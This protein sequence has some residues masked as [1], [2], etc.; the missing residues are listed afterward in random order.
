[1]PPSALVTRTLICS[2]FVA[3]CGSAVLAQGGETPANSDV[4]ARL[5]AL[6]QRVKELEGDVVQPKPNERP[7]IRHEATHST[8]R[9]FW[10]VPGTDIGIKIGGYTKLDVIHDFQD[11]GNR[12][13][14][15][16]NSIP[17]PSADQSRTTMHARESRLFL[18]VRSTMEGLPARVYVEGD[19]FGDGNQ[20]ELR[21]A[22]GQWGGLLAGQTWTT[23]M[24]V[25]SRPHTLDFEGP[26]AE[27]FSRN[28]MVRWHSELDDGW[29][30]AVAIEDATQQFANTGGAALP[31]QSITTLPDLAGNLRL[32]RESWHGQLSF[33]L[34]ELSFEGDPGNADDDALGF[35]VVLSGKTQLG[36][37]GR[38]LM[39]QVSY[40]E[41]SA[42]YCQT[43]RGTNSDAVYTATGLEV[44]TNYTAVVGYEHDWSPKWTSSLAYSLARVDDVAEQAADALRTAESASVNLVWQPNHRF[45]TGVEYLYGSRE[46]VSRQSGDAH[47][48]QFSFKF[49]F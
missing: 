40:G 16:T 12:F 46:D 8:P 13:K 4:E 32:E 25:D 18:D 27:I 44:L 37:P 30:Y 29:S 6:E 33:V 7:L 19:F 41:G 22:Y 14:F 9:G 45:L 31:G 34:R 42:Y 39:G 49:L 21:H 2:S 24:D 15:A 23:Y 1:M 47:R 3:M 43:L 28:P 48:V 20:F 38:R 35:G 36:D 11:I 17:V 26:D 10:R 5:R